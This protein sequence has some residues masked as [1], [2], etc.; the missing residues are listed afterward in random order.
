[1]TDTDA[2]GETPP[3]AGEAPDED[4]DPTAGWFAGG[5]SGVAVDDTR[6]RERIATGAADGPRDW[7]RLAVETGFAESTDAYYD[8]L[9]TATVESTRETVRERERADD[10]QLVHAVRAI[11]DMARKLA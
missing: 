6:L 3:D 10:Q 1:M 2:D 5:S 7:P 8:R 4:A 11:D 9:H